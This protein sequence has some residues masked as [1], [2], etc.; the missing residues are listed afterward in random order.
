MVSSLFQGAFLFL[1]FA[2][3]VQIPYEV[4]IDVSTEKRTKILKYKI[5]YFTLNIKVLL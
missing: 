4:S 1:S 2:D 5:F 3:M